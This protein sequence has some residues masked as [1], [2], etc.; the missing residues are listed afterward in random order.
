MGKEG[1]FPRGCLLTWFV[2]FV[3]F[4]VDGFFVLGLFLNIV[5]GSGF[6]SSP[7]AQSYPLLKVLQFIF[8]RTV[9]FNSPWADSWLNVKPPAFMPRL[10]RKKPKD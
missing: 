4:L 6:A 10:H 5:R 1:K 2:G 7:A 3:F 9:H 8:E